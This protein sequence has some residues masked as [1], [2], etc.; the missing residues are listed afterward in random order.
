MSAP[1]VARLTACLERAQ[2]SVR[3]ISDMLVAVETDKGARSSVPLM[4]AQ[5]TRAL[6]AL[7]TRRLEEAAPGCNRKLQLRLLKRE[8]QDQGPG[9]A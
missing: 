3:L 5:V 7:D 9:A 4:R 6:R 1:E 8:E 2:Q